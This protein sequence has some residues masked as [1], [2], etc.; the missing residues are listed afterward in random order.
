MSGPT[1]PGVLGGQAP[2]KVAT[3]APRTAEPCT[4]VMLG[5]SGDLAHRKLVPALY[6]LAVDRALP[7]PFG[8]VGFSR[9]PYTNEAF[10]KE[11]EEA[12]GEHSRRRP[13]DPAVW[14][15]FAKSLSYCAGDFSDP[16]SYE[17]L[18]ACLEASER[19]NR[20]GGNRIFYLATPP[21]V[22]PVI[23][24]NLAAAKLLTKAQSP[25]TRVVVEKPFGH[26]LGSA[27]ELNTSVHSACDERQFYRIDHYL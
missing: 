5:A 12:A 6:N 20:T 17:K 27:R 9:S 13:L 14:N 2:A 16:K 3:R 15:P 10:R 22:F 25:W 24:K 8:V 11:L 7:S 18:R 26:D 4:F 21:S 1:I 19:E 23:L